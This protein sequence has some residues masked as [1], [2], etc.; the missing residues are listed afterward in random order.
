MFISCFVLQRS[1]NIPYFSGEIPNYFLERALAK[2]KRMEA[3]NLAGIVRGLFATIFLVC[4]LQYGVS[5]SAVRVGKHDIA[6]R[7]SDRCIFLYS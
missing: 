4:G 3:N 6:N 1:H 5:V 7:E 2:T